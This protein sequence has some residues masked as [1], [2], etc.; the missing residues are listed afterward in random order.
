MK[1][2]KIECL[3]EI[4]ETD[5]DHKIQYKPKGKYKFFFE[6]G[7]T[8]VQDCIYKDQ[9]KDAPSIIEVQEFSE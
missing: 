6:D 8:K 4:I 5:Y 7:S 1:I 9:L 2:N 3:C